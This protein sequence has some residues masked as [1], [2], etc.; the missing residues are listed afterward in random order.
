MIPVWNRLIGLLPSAPCDTLSK[1]LCKNKHVP[2][3]YLKYYDIWCYQCIYS[4]YTVHKN[5]G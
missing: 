3:I 2:I 4:D 1:L 5:E